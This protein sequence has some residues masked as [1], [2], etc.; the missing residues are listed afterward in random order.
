MP[1]ES[2]DDIIADT[3]RAKRRIWDGLKA[4]YRATYP[5][6][7]KSWNAWIVHKLE[8]WSKPRKARETKEQKP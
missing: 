6:H 4:K 3:I 2:P 1:K 7:G 5:A 8:R